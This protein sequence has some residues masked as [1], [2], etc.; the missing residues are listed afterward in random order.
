MNDRKVVLNAERVVFYSMTDERSFFEWLA[1]MPFVLD[2]VG[3][4][5]VIEITVDTSM[6]DDD[7]LR[8][9]IAFFQRYRVSMRQLRVFDCEEFS[10]W[11]RRR[12]TFWYKKVFSDP[13]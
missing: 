12:N 1:K 5:L 7:G 11:F 9:L 6:V 2:V 13:H 4:G 8:E 10:D 3:R